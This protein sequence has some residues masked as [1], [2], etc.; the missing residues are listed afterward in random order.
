MHKV[1][2]KHRVCLMMDLCIHFPEFFGFFFFEKSFEN[3]M[4]EKNMDQSLE[5]DLCIHFP[6]FFD[7]FF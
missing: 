6:E 1:G 4:H 3:P 7:F 2:K 5:I